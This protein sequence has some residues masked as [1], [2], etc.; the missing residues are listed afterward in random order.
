MY[1]P[2]L[3]GRQY[4]LLAVRELLENSLLGHHVI[5]IIEPIKLSFT[6]LKTLESFRDVHQAIAVVQNPQV[7]NFSGEMDVA[8]ETPMP[9]N[10]GTH[11]NEKW[12]R[13]RYAEDDL[14]PRS[15]FL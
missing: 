4:E 15:Y 1:L 12:G 5:P 6:L 7:G 14:R 9:R 2:Y 3:R 13:P 8:K 11:G 10:R